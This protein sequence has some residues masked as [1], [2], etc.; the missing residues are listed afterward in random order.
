M[1]EARSTRG[2]PTPFEVETC[3]L[4]A[5]SGPCLIVHLGLSSQVQ[6]SGCDGKFCKGGHTFQSGRSNN[7]ACDET[8]R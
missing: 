8:E 5:I 7:D 3:Q 2:T 1:Q 4:G 6:G